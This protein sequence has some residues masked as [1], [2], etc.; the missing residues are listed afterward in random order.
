LLT[1]YNKPQIFKMEEFTDTIVGVL[2]SVPSADDASRL[3]RHRYENR[4]HS[5][6]ERF[7]RYIKHQ[8][9]TAV[10][11]PVR[12]SSESME[13][14]EFAAVG[15]HSSVVRFLLPMFFPE[16]NKFGSGTTEYTR[17]NLYTDEGF[18]WSLDVVLQPKQPVVAPVRAASVNP[19]VFL[20]VQ[21]N[22]IDAGR[23]VFELFTDDAPEFAGDFFQMCIG[24][25]VRPGF[26]SVDCVAR[27]VV[28]GFVAHFACTMLPEPKLR[29]IH[30]MWFKGKTK[31]HTGFGCLSKNLPTAPHFQIYTADTPWLDGKALVI[32]KL[33]SGDTV[34]RQI[35]SMGSVNGDPKAKVKITNSGKVLQL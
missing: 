29:D 32:G 27:S 23:M 4:C 24:E 6:G 34:L 17:E 25:S 20:D 11:F 26:A 7:A 12:L 14:G 15:L 22:D 10:E 13:G 8:L 3:A 28:P 21:I 16:L 19:R 33:V 18:K 35:E 31:T 5:N 9:S 1:F 2:R 30:P